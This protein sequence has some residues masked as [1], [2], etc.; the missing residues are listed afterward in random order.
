MKGGLSARTFGD[1][2]DRIRQKYK[3]NPYPNKDN[4]INTGLWN[5]IFIKLKIAPE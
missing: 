5:Q 4:N 3:N 2:S 1:S